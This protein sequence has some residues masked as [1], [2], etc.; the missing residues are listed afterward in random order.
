MDAGRVLYVMI[1]EEVGEGR[2]KEVMGVRQVADI[3]GVVDITLT[4][5][6]AN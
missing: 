3:D 6:R 4:G 1:G 5:T 2:V